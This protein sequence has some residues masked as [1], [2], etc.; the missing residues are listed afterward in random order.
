MAGMA[1]RSGDGEGEEASAEEAKA[2]SKGAIQTGRQGRRQ[3][4][5]ARTM[6]SR[7][8][9][10]R[11]RRSCR[12]FT[13]LSRLEQRGRGNDSPQIGFGLKCQDQGQGRLSKQAD[14]SPSQTTGLRHVGREDVTTASAA[15]VSE[16]EDADREST[17]EQT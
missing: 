15:N 10:S 1:G 6:Y 7:I 8:E 2:A 13:S 16:C 3:I 9:G 11:W 17:C 14:C 4:V 12:C 5:R